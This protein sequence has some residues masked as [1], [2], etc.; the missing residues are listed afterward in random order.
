MIELSA[1]ARKA[2]DDMVASLEENCQE[3]LVNVVESD[4]NESSSTVLCT[5][6]PAYSKCQ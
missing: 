5:E 3:Q 2:Y 4:S 6:E 1:Q